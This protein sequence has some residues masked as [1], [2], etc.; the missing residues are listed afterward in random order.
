MPLP[1]KGTE[2]EA[3]LK[4]RQRDQARS[5]RVKGKRDPKTPLS[6]AISKPSSS[7][8]SGSRLHKQ[9]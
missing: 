1:P 6:Q 5:E 2:E 7:G 8:L 3:G 9:R 4:Q